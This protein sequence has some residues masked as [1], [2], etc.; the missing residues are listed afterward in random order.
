MK[1]F[2]TNLLK[3]GTTPAILIGAMWYIFIFI[4]ESKALLWDSAVQKVT[5]IQR[6]EALPTPRE[7][8]RQ[9]V[10]DSMNTVSAIRSRS[11][12]DSLQKEESRRDSLTA[13]TIYQMKEEIEMINIKI[14]N[15]NTE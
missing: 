14:K 6:V 11:L 8:A 5:T 12:R 7:Q 9:Y 1:Q 4:G 3:Y 10:L 2:G 15:N 13:T